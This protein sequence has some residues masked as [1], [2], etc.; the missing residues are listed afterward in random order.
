ML[1]SSLKATLLLASKLYAYET[2]IVLKTDEIYVLFY[3]EVLFVS[4]KIHRLEIYRTYF[5]KH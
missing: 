1:S 2:T 5:V 3:Q 4:L